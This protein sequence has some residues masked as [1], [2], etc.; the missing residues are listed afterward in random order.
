MYPSLPLEY[1]L[2]SPPPSAPPPLYHQQTPPPQRRPP[3]PHATGVPAQHV[4]PPPLNVNW[5]SSLCACCSDVPNC[6]LTC[7]CPC[8]TFGQIAEII[9]QGNTSCGEHGAL[10][11]L[12]QAFTGCG[13]LYSCTN[14][15]KMRSQFGLREN[16][17]PD[18]LVHFFCEPC[19]LCQEY[20]ELKH[21]G[22]DISIGWEGNMER[23]NDVHMPPM[24]PG[25]MYR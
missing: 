3:Q 1:S 20:R 18:C 14:R 11:A 5:S 8:I 6:C 7:L 13:C 23:Q 15:T 9:D 19:A 12:I 21:R 25:G 16:P 2:R 10:Y 22:F 4:T 24:A 17:C